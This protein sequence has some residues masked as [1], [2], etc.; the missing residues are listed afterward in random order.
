MFSH[1]CYSN[2]HSRTQ[3][4]SLPSLLSTLNPSWAHRAVLN[5]PGTPSPLPLHHPWC[6]ATDMIT[7]TTSTE[8]VVAMIT[9]MTMGTGTTTVMSMEDAAAIPIPMPPVSCPRPRPAVAMRN[10]AMVSALVS[11]SLMK[12]CLQR[13]QALTPYREV[14]LCCRGPRVWEGLR[15]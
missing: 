7:A 10:V 3:L 1:L 15:R 2:H 6:I 5:Q 12:S 11:T 4:I 8:V 9:S 14:H 13:R